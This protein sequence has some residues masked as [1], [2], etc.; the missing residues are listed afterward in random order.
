VKRETV[1]WMSFMWGVLVCVSFAV[2][3]L[4]FIEMSL[5]ICGL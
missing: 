4:I 5:F 2:A 1:D 3:I